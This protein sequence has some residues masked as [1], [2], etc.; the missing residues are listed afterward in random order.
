MVE[1]EEIKH[2]GEEEVA[3]V[4]AEA[5][6]QGD[7]E[8]YLRRTPLLLPLIEM[9]ILCLMHNNFARIYALQSTLH[10]T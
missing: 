5:T 3:E 7:I 8:K 10:L 4:E 6:V 9:Y 1:G 2:A